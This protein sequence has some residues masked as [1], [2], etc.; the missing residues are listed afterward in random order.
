MSIINKKKILISIEGQTHF[1]DEIVEKFYLDYD[2]IIDIWEKN[3]NFDERL[4]MLNQVEYI[5]C[6]WCSNNAIW[7]SNNKKHH[8]K[9]IIRLHRW[10]LY[11]KHFFQT[12][13]K[14]VNSV[15]FISPHIQNEAIY[16]YSQY[17]RL[18]EKNFDKYYYTQNNEEYFDKN[19]IITN[20]WKHFNDFIKKTHGKIPNFK[21]IGTNSEFID[22]EFKNKTI[23]IPNYIKKNV[24]ANIEKNE[25]SKYNLGLIGYIPKLKRADI[26]IEILNYLV[27]INPNYKLFVVGKNLEEISW[28]KKNKSELDYVSNL[29][30]LIKKY[31]LESN[32]F[33]ENYN[34]NI[35]EWFKKISYILGTSDIEGCHH[36]LAEGMRCGT[37]PLIYGNALKKYKLNLIYMDKFCFFDNNIINLCKKVIELNE[38]DELR[39]EYLTECINYSK[40]IFD[41]DKIYSEINLMIN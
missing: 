31:N 33:F 20:E 30:N 4:K 27:K 39:L 26:A 5:F 17:F 40:E 11:A 41:F 10:E 3:K 19:E 6:E 38:N 9:L 22:I 23:F 24:F 16:R 21:T 13:W 25:N 14:N 37:I 8:Q 36:S 28:L 32:I 18:N 7:Y 12:N 29:N 15:I 2:V 1:I 35:G 34:D